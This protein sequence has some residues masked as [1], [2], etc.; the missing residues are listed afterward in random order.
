MGDWLRING[1]AIYGAGRTPFGEELGRYDSNGTANPDP[2]RFIEKRDWRCTT[3]P[4]ELYFHLFKWPGDTFET[5]PIMGRVK[6]AYLLSD[7]RPLSFRQTDKQ[8]TVTLPGGAPRL[9]AHVLC[10]ETGAK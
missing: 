5:P 8:V 9:S 4:G 2:K 3:Q 1:E 6:A 10:L 7:R